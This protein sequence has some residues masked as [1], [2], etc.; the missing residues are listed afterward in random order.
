MPEKLLEPC[1]S[2]AM[3]SSATNL[4][5]SNVLIKVTNSMFFSTQLKLNM[6]EMNKKVRTGNSIEIQWTC[7]NSFPQASSFFIRAC[8]HS[9]KLNTKRLE[10][11][12]WYLWKQ[13]DKTWRGVN[14][15]PPP[16]SLN[17]VNQIYTEVTTWCSISKRNGLT[18]VHYP[19]LRP[20]AL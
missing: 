9:K 14:F 5:N 7:A 2:W 1:I 10:L 16:P 13:G 20:F 17:G 3:L 11:F 6:S 12:G 15:T 19:Q 4:L 8:F 18:L